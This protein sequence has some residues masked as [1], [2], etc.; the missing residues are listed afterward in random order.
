[1][2]KELESLSQSLLILERNLKTLSAQVS[3]NEQTINEASIK[4][5]RDYESLNLK[6][7]NVLNQLNQI[8]STIQ[9]INAKLMALEVNF[10]KVK[11]YVEEEVTPE[12]KLLQQFSG[13]I[14]A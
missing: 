11:N 13:E 12:I 7:N 1:M 2:S 9:V 4:Q 8:E 14:I 10:G 5:L 6:F 3:N